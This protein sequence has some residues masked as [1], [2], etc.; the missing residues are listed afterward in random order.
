ML[1]NGEVELQALK[2]RIWSSAFNAAVSTINIYTVYTIVR[3]E[4]NLKGHRFNKKRIE[5]T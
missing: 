5:L 1:L 3:G 2:M 4:N